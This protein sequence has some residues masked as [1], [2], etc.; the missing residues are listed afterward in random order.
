VEYEEL[1]AV[2]DPE[3]AILPGL[4]S[5]TRIFR[6]ISRIGCSLKRRCE[7]GLQEADLVED[8]FQTQRVHQCYLEPYGC[9]ASWDD[10]DRL[11]LWL[12]NMNIS[13]V[14][15][16]VSWILGLPVS[17]VRVIQPFVG[18]SFGSKSLMNEIYPVSA[19]LSRLTR[20]PVKMIFHPGRRIL[21]QPA[22]I[23]RSL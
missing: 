23:L 9:V 22:S 6:A 1:P 13:G 10:Q 2:F 20:R 17:K 11:T 12:G 5:C 16:L 14:R 8:R 19:I 3:E 7:Q 18:G 21:L 15:G 4:L